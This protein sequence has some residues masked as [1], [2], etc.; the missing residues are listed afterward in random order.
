MKSD[1]HLVLC[2]F[3]IKYD[4]HTISHFSILLKH[5]L[6]N[7]ESSCLLLGLCVGWRDTTGRNLR[8]ATSLNN[9]YV[10]WLISPLNKKLIADFH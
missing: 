10:Y 5:A 7:L 3:N 4:I 9:T 6:E 2:K 8:S 1:C